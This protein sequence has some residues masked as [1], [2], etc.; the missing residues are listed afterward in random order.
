MGPAPVSMAVASW[1][2]HAGR[3]MPTQCVTASSF[4]GLRHIEVARERVPGIPRDCCSSAARAGNNLK[5][6]DLE[7][8]RV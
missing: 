5:C 6:V 7:I 3:I 1:P 8:R 4:S 2:M